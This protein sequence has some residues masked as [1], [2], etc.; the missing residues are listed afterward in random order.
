MEVVMT[1]TGL[2][3]IEEHLK[4]FD[5]VAESTETMAEM[6][7]AIDEA[8]KKRWGKGIMDETETDLRWGVHEPLVL[9]GSLRDS[10]KVKEVTPTSVTYGTDLY[11]ARFLA[12]GTRNMKKKRLIRLPRKVIKALY[13]ELIRHALGDRL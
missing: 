4:A 6:G 3:K 8:T 2:D 7:K 13:A 10:F 11:Y 12:D 1:T 9:S 5:H